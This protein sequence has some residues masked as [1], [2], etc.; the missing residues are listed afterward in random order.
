MSRVRSLMLLTMC[1]LLPTSG[2]SDP[3]KRI[4]VYA[5]RGA[6]S[7]APEN[8][9]AGYQTALH[10]GADWLDMD[11]VLTKEHEVL[12][13]HDLILNPDTT[14]NEHGEFLAPNREALQKLPLAERDA[15][16]RKYASWGLTLKELQRFDVGRLNPASAYARFFPDQLPVDGTRMPTLREVVRYADKATRQMIRYQVE[17]KTDPAHPAYSPPPEAFAAAVYKLLK[18]EGI[19]ERVEV[20]AFD[21]RCLYELQKLDRRIQTA[22]L[23][24]RD[25]EKAGAESFFSPDPQVAGLWTGGKLVREYGGS[26]PAMVKALGGMAWDPEDAQLTKE[27]LDEAHR[28]GLK[29]VVWSWPEKLG[30]AFDAPLVA[31]MIEW[32]VDGIITDDP[33]RL[34]SMLAARGLPV[35]VRY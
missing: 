28:L 2:W 32:G 27:A 3:V 22:Y 4:Q 29:V 6:R 5:H 7:F 10:I 23:T 25:N 11:V 31:K 24:S 20:H 9:I 8:T 15:Y 26:I 16:D 34:I 1:V 13:S 33:G 30:T 18:D 21:F 12:L 17:M 19:I 35:P 14:R